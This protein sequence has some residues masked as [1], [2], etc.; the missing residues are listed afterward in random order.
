MKKPKPSIF[1]RFMAGESLFRLALLRCQRLG[2]HA[3]P[4]L[5]CEHAI[6]S[7]IRRASKRREQSR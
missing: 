5:R 7:A 3:R 4:C 6:E 1:A 2:H